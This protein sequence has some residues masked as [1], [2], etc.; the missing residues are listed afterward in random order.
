MYFIFGQQ[1][2]STREILLQ[3]LKGEAT[4][5][6][7][8]IVDLALR[9]NPATRVAWFQ[10]RASAADLGSKRAAY[11]PEIDLDANLTR[12]KTAAVGGRFTYL[13]TTY[14]PSASLNYLLFN[15][16]GREADTDEARQA[17]F[18]ANWTHDAA[19]Q[20]LV[21]QV[22]QAYYQYLDAKALAASAQ[23]SF[24]QAEENLA[25]AE[26]RHRAGVATIADVLQAKTARSQAQLALTAARG[27]I[28]TYRGALA[29]AVGVSPD[30]PVE[31]GE[32]PEIANLEEVGQSVDALIATARSERPDLAAAWFEAQKAES[33]VRSVRA[34]GL[35]SLS[36]AGTIGRTYYYNPVG[37]AY[38]NNYSGAI[39]FRFPLFMGFQNRYD[40]LKAQEEASAARAQV[41]TLSNLVI[42][43]VWSSYYGVQTATQQVR[44]ARDLLASA[45]QS[46]EVAL[47]RYKA[48]VG[49]ILDL[50]TAQSALAS[51]RA[52]EVLARAT[53]FLALAQ[54]AHDTGAL[55]PPAG[56]PGPPPVSKGQ[57]DSE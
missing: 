26:E 29:T 6:L 47:A 37:A 13:Q 43:Q 45:Q 2:Y 1:L 51:A 55:T 24:Q 56:A 20:N 23:A 57:R 32:L 7:D 40:T 9:N 52:E 5:S 19:I 49:S 16:G 12:Q 22:E 11:F 34:E 8:E 48:G 21:L 17:L 25:A 46:Q 38:S 41:D 15:F 35:P 44:T 36:A 30:I 42:F 50:L 53:W 39:L 33:H 54:L 3:Y 14:G 28:Q 27:L 4:A 18:A 10:A 31:V